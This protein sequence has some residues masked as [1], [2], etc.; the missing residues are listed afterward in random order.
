MNEHMTADIL[1]QWLDALDIPRLTDVFQTSV[2]NWFYVSFERTLSPAD[3]QSIAALGFAVERTL[4]LP[5]RYSLVWSA[6]EDD[7]P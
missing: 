1:Q 4:P 6:S 2:P 5:N 7:E 3:K